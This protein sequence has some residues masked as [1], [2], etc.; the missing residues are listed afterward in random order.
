[1]DF[2]L[3]EEQL[4]LR[5]TVRRL[6]GD[7]F[8]LD[9]LGRRE[10]GR[11]DR[12]AWRAL[13][14]LGAFAMLRPQ[15]SG[16]SGFGHVGAA[17][18]FEQLGAHLVCGP[19]VW[20]T[21][22]ASLVDGAADGTRIVCGVEDD[23]AQSRAPLLVEHA[24]DADAL[25]VLRPDGVHVLAAGDLPSFTP[26]EPLD[27]LT[28]I[29]GVDAMPRGVQ[30]GDA[31]DAGR[32]RT[33]GTL[34]AAALLLGVS[35]AALDLSR[36]WALAR[37]QFGVPIGSFQAIQHLLADMYVRTAMARSAVYAAAATL[38]DP[39]VGDPRRAAAAAKLLA[40]DAARENARTAIQIHGGMG[41]TWEM[42][43]H[44]LLKRAWVLEHAFG[45]GDAHALALGA[46][47]EDGLA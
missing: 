18:V 23:P 41:F 30:V 31:A 28:P 39:A 33:A 9:G 12:D 19:L 38:D 47:I 10:T 46:A 3:D 24:A 16:G 32:M 43:P 21:L 1:M 44:Y 14:D 13:G 45:D 20:T 27:P 7:R 37:E 8:A 25:L 15:E 42:A 26:L 17:I 36:L 34:L 5:D 40:G 2:R 6:C 11:L 35:D 4:E 29:A 22:A